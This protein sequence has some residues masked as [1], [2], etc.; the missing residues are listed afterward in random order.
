MLTFENPAA[1]RIR[2][3]KRHNPQFD[4][5]PIS[6]FEDAQRMRTWPCP[7][8]GCGQVQFSVLFHGDWYS[9]VHG[10]T[11]DGHSISGPTHLWCF[12]GLPLSP[13]YL[14]I[15]QLNF[16]SSLNLQVIKFFWQILFGFFFFF[17]DVSCT[18]TSNIEF[19]FE[20]I[21]PWSRV[22]T[23]DDLTCIHC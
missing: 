18:Y 21:G 6:R 1:T 23:P 19:I 4:Y 15:Q 14:L 17:N 3:Q 9:N 16:V 7:Q 11:I 8:E 2:R 5:R 13:S 12:Q 20:I 22:I 10:M